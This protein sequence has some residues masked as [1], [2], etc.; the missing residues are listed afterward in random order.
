MCTDM[1]I[2]ACIDMRVAM[3]TDMCTGAARGEGHAGVLDVP[4]LAHDT[5]VLGRFSPLGRTQASVADVV[6]AARVVPIPRKLPADTTH[7]STLDLRRLSRGTHH[8]RING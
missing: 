6:V 1:C 8:M 2:D 4:R 3:C 7:P 5:A